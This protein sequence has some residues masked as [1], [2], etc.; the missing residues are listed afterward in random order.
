M[1]H[2]VTDQLPPE[3]SPQQVIE[4]V[5]DFASES[6]GTACTKVKDVVKKNPVPTVLGALVFGA[7]VGY[8]VF[9]RSQEERVTDRLVRES[10]SARDRLSSARGRF[11]SLLHDGYDSASSGASKA[12]DFLHD[13]P[14]SDLVDSVSKTLNRL[15]NRLKF[16]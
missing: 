6:C 8:L 13:L 11:S 3:Q 7:A 10:L 14:T 16:W 4:K 2:P 12:S 15:S 1:K 5:K 9:S